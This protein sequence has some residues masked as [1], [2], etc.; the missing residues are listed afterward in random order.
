MLAEVA[1]ICDSRLQ[2]AKA[3]RIPPDEIARSGIAQSLFALYEAG[4]R[5]AG[6]SVTDVARQFQAEC[7][8]RLALARLLDADRYGADMRFTRRPI[9][10]EESAAERAAFKKNKL[11]ILREVRKKSPQHVPVDKHGNIIYDEAKH[12]RYA[13]IVT[14][15]DK[16]TGEE[17]GDLPR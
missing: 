12:G 11:D 16:R 8:R 10:E 9:L 6:L 5:K 4:G 13:V 2:Q 17:C 1:Q 15:V 7:V 14:R 3:Q